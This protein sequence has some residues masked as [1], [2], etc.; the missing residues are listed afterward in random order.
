MKKT[1]S[2][3]LVLL[4]G[5]LLSACSV[6][7][8]SGLPPDVDTDHLNQEI[9]LYALRELND[10]KLGK[11][12]GLYLEYNAE[13]AL[14]EIVFSNTF[15]AKIFIQVDNTWVEVKEKPTT[16]LFDDVIFPNPYVSYV[17]IIDPDLDLSKPKT[18]NVRVYVFGDMK[19]KDGM[20]KVG[21][22][23]DFKLFP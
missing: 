3:L 10:F 9:K 6:D 2:L 18:Y 8:E 12:I 14:G 15:D 17:V 4:L 16:R 23:V 20:Q 7:E 21:A 13:K 5:L 1:C 22:F 19:T 11:V